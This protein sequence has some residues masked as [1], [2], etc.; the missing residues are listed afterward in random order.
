[1]TSALTVSI[2]SI[3]SVFLMWLLRRVAQDASQAPHSEPLASTALHC[4]KACCWR[5][6]FLFFFKS[7]QNEKTTRVHSRKKKQHK[8]SQLTSYQP[9]CILDRCLLRENENL[10]STYVSAA[11]R[12]MQMASGSGRCQRLHCGG[13]VRLYFPLQKTR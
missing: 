5:L 13:G 6:L 8:K 9:K 11:P 10:M 4:N 2:S 3:F 12:E 1:M 7:R